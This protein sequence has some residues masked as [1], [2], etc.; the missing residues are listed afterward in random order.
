MMVE[1]PH[2]TSPYTLREDV[3]RSRDVEEAEQDRRD[4]KCHQRAGH[5]PWRFV[6]LTMT[7]VL[8]EEGESDAAGHVEGGDESAG[9]GDPQYAAKLR[10]VAE[11][12]GVDTDTL[13]MGQLDYQALPQLYRDHDIFVYASVWDKPLGFQSF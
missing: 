8:P 10:N 9:D 12:L 1:H 13:F 11:D 4:G 6:R 7:L 3:G 2:E 5:Y